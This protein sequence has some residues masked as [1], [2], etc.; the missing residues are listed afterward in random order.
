M[1]K[2]KNDNLA[3]MAPDEVCAW[4]R[5]K[6][7]GKVGDRQENQARVYAS[8]GRYYIKF[9]VPSK[10]ADYSGSYRRSQ[11]VELF[12]AMGKEVG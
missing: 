11:L 3:P 2:R 1:V 4:I 8:H 7:R 6:I 5:G 10:Y 12:K 9:H